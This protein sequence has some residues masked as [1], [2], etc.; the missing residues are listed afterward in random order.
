ML[1]FDGRARDRDD[2]AHLERWRLFDRNRFRDRFRFDDF[3]ALHPP[4]GRG[5]RGGHR[6][7]RADDHEQQ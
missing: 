2:T 5:R 3:T 6:R 7:D 4:F 1:Y